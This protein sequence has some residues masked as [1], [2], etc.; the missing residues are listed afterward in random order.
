[1]V[2]VTVARI[3]VGYETFAESAKIMALL[4]GVGYAYETMVWCAKGIIVCRAAINGCTPII[5]LAGS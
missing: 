2:R 4:K 1:M 5:I 3:R